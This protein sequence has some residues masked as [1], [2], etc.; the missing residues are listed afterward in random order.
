MDGVYLDA[1]EAGVLGARSAGDH[2]V[3][4]LVDLLYGHGLLMQCRIPT[5]LLV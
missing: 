1:V 3:L 2:V 5:V 4:E